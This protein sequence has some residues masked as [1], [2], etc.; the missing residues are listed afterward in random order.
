MQGRRASSRPIYSYPPTHILCNT[1]RTH[2]YPPHAYAPDPFIPP[3]THTLRTQAVQWLRAHDDKARAISRAGR[4]L[5]LQVN[6]GRLVT[7]PSL[8][9]S[10]LTRGVPL[11]PRLLVG[12]EIK[13]LLAHCLH[14]MYI[15]G[16][17][18]L[19][20]PACSTGKRCL[21]TWLH[22][23][24][25]ALAAACTRCV[26]RSST[27]SRTWV[28]MRS[29]TPPGRCAGCTNRCGR[30]WECGT[31][32]GANSQTV[33]WEYPVACSGMHSAG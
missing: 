5:V 8:S 30:L 4:A 20:L 23:R 15:H 19:T 22:S 16:R 1:L 31:V 14:T 26:S 7:T 32:C 6:H 13:T 11:E 12:L 33:R 24:P 2:L 17:C 29:P 3:H 28:G 21:S 25:T 18:C 10:P 9:R 27:R